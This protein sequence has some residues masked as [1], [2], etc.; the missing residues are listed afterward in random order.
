MEV[1]EYGFD[2][3]GVTILF[4]YAERFD[5]VGGGG[6]VWIVGRFGCGAVGGCLCFNYVQSIPTNELDN[7]H[8]PE[9]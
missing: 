7:A 9:Q 8:K 2:S 4:E 6:F 3:P 5:D 1:E